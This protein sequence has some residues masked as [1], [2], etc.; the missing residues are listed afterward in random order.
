MNL[1][2]IEVKNYSKND[3]DISKRQATIYEALTNQIWD[4]LSL[5]IM[6]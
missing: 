1:D 6:K 4:N 5:K 2:Y 3:R